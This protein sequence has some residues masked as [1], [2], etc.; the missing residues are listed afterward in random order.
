[1]QSPTIKPL[2]TLIQNHQ[3]LLFAPDSQKYFS[4]LSN[5][6]KMLDINLLAAQEEGRNLRIAIVGQMN[7]ENPHS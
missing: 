4:E 1:M 7:E 2:L 3:S 5:M 6:A